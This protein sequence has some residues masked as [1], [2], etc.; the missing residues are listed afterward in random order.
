M[1]QCPICKRKSLRWRVTDDTYICTRTNRLFDKDFKEVQKD[2][3]G[4]TQGNRYTLSIE[5]EDGIIRKTLT[6]YLEPGKTTLKGQYPKL[7]SNDKC[8]YPERNSCN[9]EVGSERCKYMEYLTR[10]WECTYT[11]Q[12]N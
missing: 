3:I 11:S 12:L 7:H 4:D 10:G 5:K 9:H 6:Y 2:T 1:E 8:A